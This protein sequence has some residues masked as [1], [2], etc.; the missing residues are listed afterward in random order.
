MA[1]SKK[2][3][4]FELNFPLAP[5]HT[6]D[7]SANAIKNVANALVFGRNTTIPYGD[8]KVTMLLREYL[9]GYGRTKILFHLYPGG[10]G[11]SASIDS[12]KTAKTLSLV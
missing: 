6:Y 5:K 4:K 3:E 10:K 2:V 8:S 7:L 12:L 11:Y 9:G 1:A